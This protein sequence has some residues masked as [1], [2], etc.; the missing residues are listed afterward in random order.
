MASRPSYRGRYK[1]QKVGFWLWNG[2]GWED[3]RVTSFGNGSSS[4][5]LPFTGNLPKFDSNTFGGFN[6]SALSNLSSYNVGNA[7]GGNFGFNSNL[8]FSNLNLNLDNFQATE[9]TPTPSYPARGTEKERKCQGKR[10]IIVRHNGSGGTY[11]DPPQNIIGSCGYTPPPVY[12]VRGTS[13]GTE[14]QGTTKVRKL[15]NGSGGYYYETIE[16]NSRT[17]GYEPPSPP[18]IVRTNNDVNGTVGSPVVT[19]DNEPDIIPEPDNIRGSNQ[20]TIFFDQPGGTSSGLT[21][22]NSNLDVGIGG[23]GS[24]GGSGGT[25]FNPVVNEPEFYTIP[26]LYGPYPDLCTAYEQKKA[27]GRQNLV[28]DRDFGDAFEVRVFYS[29]I[30][31][32]GGFL[33]GNNNAF[34]G[35]TFTE[36][37]LVKR[38]FRGNNQWYYDA[39]NGTIIQIDNGGNNQ[40]FRTE[41]YA[42]EECKPKPII[43]HTLNVKVNYVKGA[44]HPSSNSNVTSTKSG[45]NGSTGQS[46]TFSTI[47]PYDRGALETYGTWTA[48]NSTKSSTSVYKLERST[49]AGG[50]TLTLKKNGV[51]VS[52]QT[53]KFPKDKTVRNVSSVEFNL[54]FD[55]EKVI[56]PNYLYVNPSNLSASPNSEVKRFEVKSTHSGTIGGIPDWVR[57]SSTFDADADGGQNFSIEFQQAPNKESKGSPSTRTATITF[58]SSTGKT[59]TL[60]ISQTMGAYI[61]PPKT[62]YQGIITIE[63]KAGSNAPRTGVVTGTGVPEWSN[64]QWG[65]T[66]QYPGYSIILDAST[67][68]E[69]TIST[70]TGRTSNDSSTSVWVIT[71][72]WDGSQFKIRAKENGST[73]YTKTYIIKGSGSGAS[74]APNDGDYQFTLD[75]DFKK[76]VPPDPFLV[77]TPPALNPVSRDGGAGQFLVQSSSPVIIQSKPSWVTLPA[78]ILLDTRQN[79]SYAANNI[80]QQRVGRVVFVNSQGLTDELLIIQPAAKRKPPSPTSFQVRIGVQYSPGTNAPTV[81]FVNASGA[82]SLNGSWGGGGK[83]FTQLTVKTDRP[84]V[85][86]SLVTFTGKGGDKTALNNYKLFYTYENGGFDLMLK[87]DTGD[88]NYREFENKHFN[89]GV[90]NQLIPTDGEMFNTLDWDFQKSKEVDTTP[91]SPPTLRIESQQNEVWATLEVYDPILNRTVFE[92]GIATQFTLREGRIKDILSQNAT[93]YRVKIVPRQGFTVEEWVQTSPTNLNLQPSQIN[94]FI[95][96][97]TTDVEYYWQFSVVKNTPPSKKIEVY[98]T[99]NSIEFNRKDT[100]DEVTIPYTSSTDTSYV[101]VKL[102]G[103]QE[104]K[105]LPKNGKFELESDYFKSGLGRYTLIFCP[106]SSD[107]TKGNEKTVV[108]NVVEKSERFYPDIRDI[109]W[110]RTIKGKDFVGFDVPFSF[111]YKSVFTDYVKVYLNDKDT[112]IGDKFGKVDRVKLNV[113]DLV[114]MTGKYTKS[115]DKYTFTF[116]LVPFNAQGKEILEGKTEKI[117]IVFDKGDYTLD[118]NK[119]I[120]DLCDAFAAD[121]DYKKFDEYTSTYLTHLL[122]FGDT[123]NE[124]ISNWEADTE[125]FRKYKI[126]PVTGRETNKKEEGGFD[127]LV[128]K[129]YEPLETTVQPNQQVWITKIQSKPQLHEVIIRESS[130]ESCPPLAGPNFSLVNNSNMGYE[131]LDDMVASGSDSNMKL[132][133]AFVSKSGID[134]SK[135]DIQ[136]VSGSITYDKSSGTYDSSSQRIYWEN[137][138][139][140]GS[141]EERVK[142]FYYK[143]SLIENYKNVSASLST[144]DSSTSLSIIR[145]REEQVVKIA[146]LENAFDGFEKF[147]YENTS[148]LSYPKDS[149][150]ELLG[151]GSAD[152]LNWLTVT[153]TSASIHDV[154]NKNYLANNIPQFV[155]NDRENDDFVLFLDMIGHHFDI[156]W[157]YVEALNRQRRLEHKL[158]RGVSDDMVRE[159]LKSFGYT[160]N[161]T[162]DTAPLWEFALGQYNSQNSARTDGTTKSVLTGKDRQNQIWRRILN[163]LPYLY[164]S[165]GT[166]RGL[167]ATLS[168]YGIPESFLS[169]REFGGPHPTTDKRQKLT[170]VEQ[171]FAAKMGGLSKISVPWHSGSPYPHTIEVSVNT[172]KQQDGTIFKTDGMELKMFKDTGSLAYFEFHISGSGNIISASTDT[173]PFFN[174]TYTSFMVSRQYTSGSTHEG[175]DIYVKEPF[176]QRIRSQVSASV[177]ASYGE[178]SWESGS[179]LVFEDFSGSIDNIKLWKTA[180]SESIFNEHVLAPD[181]Y[182]GN[183]ISASTEDLYFRLDFEVAKNFA[184]SSSFSPSGSYKNTAP[185][186]DLYDSTFATMSNFDS[187]S[188]YPYG[189]LSVIEK[190]ITMTVPNTGLGDADKIRIEEQTLLTQLSPKARATKSALKEKPIDS[191]KIGMFISPTK[192]V[193]L[194][195][196]KA[197]GSTFSIDDFIGDPR[198][199]YEEEYTELKNF[200]K[201]FFSK[202]TLN[203]DAFYNLIKY[204]DNSLFQALKGQAPSRSKVVTGLLIEPHILERNKAQ[205]KKPS[206]IVFEGLV[207]TEDISKN[208][209]IEISSENIPFEG[210]LTASNLQRPSGEQNG[211]ETTLDYNFVENLSG[212]NASYESTIDYDFVE[213]LSGSQLSYESTIDFNFVENLSGSQL[214]YESVIS[215]NI[216]PIFSTQSV[217]ASGNNNLSI[218]FEISGALDGNTSGEYFRDNIVPSQDS[219][220]SNLGYGVTAKDGHA[221]VTFL[222]PNGR[223]KERRKY[224]LVTEEVTRK[225]KVL[226][227]SGD[228]SSGYKTVNETENVKKLTYVSI[229]GSAPAVTGSITEVQPINGNLPSHYIYVKDTSTG[230]ENSF[231]NGC[232]QT[233]STTIDG[234]PAFETFVTNPNTLKVSDSGR[235]S[236]EPI[237]E[238]E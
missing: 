124:V 83:Y 52:T 113:Q 217:D 108:V 177:S 77:V 120:K 87:Q 210:V 126:D 6:F 225:V 78:N 145:E 38:P 12:P 182:N 125:T 66:R 68:T 23:G 55:Y 228:Q 48:Q 4:A 75:W 37:E 206:G 31:Q 17:C 190:E 218:I 143:A 30:R 223:R 9:P 86:R 70:I 53:V 157:T 42:S 198:D 121:L 151:T 134:T 152:V 146:Q 162:L 144:G 109:N 28:S 163:N 20:E 230:L 84:G 100:G 36:S 179:E 45:I 164:K 2:Y 154:E 160:P 71:S 116:L 11:N 178:S 32:E 119:V 26:T 188:T 39:S 236:G 29:S 7:S 231:F 175:F 147:L 59:D 58:T 82:P 56:P 153:E 73:R 91:P 234:G 156:L 46:K 176:Q 41:D 74:A 214:S 207:G 139:H 99:V 98:P 193:N 199:I 18:V 155:K 136:Y 65:E 80:E 110:P 89:V 76:V 167:K 132:V 170:T 63:N 101:N 130:E 60:E 94:R 184:V 195:I 27:G 51:T 102:P 35:D 149:S 196:V 123:D 171:S 19:P 1:G 189:G 88:G 118:R 61:E 90:S 34:G 133:N 64:M 81:G 79:I 95:S 215:E 25:K 21:G 209:I 141:A 213:N 47:L 174:D 212:S 127:A 185:N 181:M 220:I 96:L 204:V 173:I 191:N 107:G 208:S 194:D 150:G 3:T 67:T 169:V 131:L 168:T 22:M 114:N 166:S 138:S 192:N 112:R 14:C 92:T 33:G 104:I 135:L 233:Q 97:D 224:Y 44:N 140:F 50:H 187:S 129:L 24:S 85:E 211:Y 40:G 128:L 72:Q 57:M 232:K 200:R 201:S 122:H 49:S 62:S 172:E 117:T 13:A 216:N 148:S 106:Y 186:L 202:Y 238:V 142:N 226:N 159:M 43:P 197:M 8:D 229:S 93:N 158:T 165:K 183:S 203:Y 103:G 237:L 16:R 180:L 15:H 105:N 219:D 161:T 205:R 235:G 5:G 111:T 54:K 221:I 69:Q 115:G 227:I 10:T 137:F 222:T